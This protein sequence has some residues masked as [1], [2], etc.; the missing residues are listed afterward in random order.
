VIKTIDIKNYKSVD[1]LTFELGRVN[2]F[3]GEN[4]C[5]KTNILEALA[6]AAASAAGKLENEFLLSRGIRA[7]EPVKMRSGFTKESET[8]KIQIEVRGAAIDKG[9]LFKA[10][11]HHDNSAYGQW[12][13]GIPQE[14]WRDLL[15]NGPAATF[16]GFTFAEVDD[17]L[18]SGTL[19][20]DDI[21]AHGTRIGL[22]D[23]SPRDIVGISLAKAMRSAFAELLGLKDFLIYTPTEEALRDLSRE[24]HIEPIGLH[25]E[26]LF[27]LLNNLTPEQLAELQ[28]HLRLIHWFDGLQVLH[29]AA[30][31]LN[32]INIVDQYLG[33]GI[34]KFDQRSANE[35]FLFLLLYASLL[36]SSYTPKFFAIDNVDTALNPKLSAGVI[37]M[38]VEAA[39]KHDR[40]VLLTTHNPGALDG[41]DLQDPEQRLFVVYRNIEGRTRI[42]RIQREAGENLPR[43]SEAFLQGNLGGLPNH[44]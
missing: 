18:K 2:V 38:F 43:L 4:G 34:A 8:Q 5:G 32:A 41:L 39:K 29:G 36:V 23:F 14:T 35:G 17:L 44:F 20:Q 25:G 42:R 19:P 16:P 24:S 6:L 40:Q 13:D 1:E 26:G 10:H 7:T 21:A 31:S 27:K 3:I 12:M 37:K 9:K 15:R 33:E 28:K 22:Q 11:L 30:P